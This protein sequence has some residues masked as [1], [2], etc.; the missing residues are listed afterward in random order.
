[1]TA[2]KQKLLAFQQ[3]QKKAVRLINYFFHFLL[4]PFFWILNVLID[5]A[6]F[7]YLQHTGG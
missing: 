4:P 6:Y 7:W 1:M 5:P 3:A 2:I